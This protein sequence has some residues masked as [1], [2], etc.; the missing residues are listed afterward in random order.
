MEGDLKKEKEQILEA[1]IERDL[2]EI[3]ADASEIT[4]DEK[5]VE[6]L[7]HELAELREEKRVDVVID[8]TPYELHYGEDTTV[9][10]LITEALKKSGNQGRPVGDWQI[11]YN[12][13]VLD[14]NAKVSSYHLPCD[15]VLFLS[16]RAGHLG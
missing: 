13:A 7:R 16:L 1:V 6:K 9:K 5:E 10:T 2:E 4:R 14:E 3:A 12:G 8:G 15:A 11:K